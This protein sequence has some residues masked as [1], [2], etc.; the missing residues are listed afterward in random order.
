MHAGI[1]KILVVYLL[2]MYLK[3]EP[4]IIIPVRSYIHHGTPAFQL[5]LDV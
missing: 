1:S 4:G 2:Q 3:S 5:P